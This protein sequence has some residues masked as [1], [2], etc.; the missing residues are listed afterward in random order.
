MAELSEQELLLLSTIIYEDSIVSGNFETIESLVDYYI[1]L[2]KE[3]AQA[4]GEGTNY[5]GDF[6]HMQTRLDDGEGG[7]IPQEEFMYIIKEINENHPELLKLE[8]Q[9]PVLSEYGRS[10]ITAVCLVNPDDGKATVVIRGTDTSYTAWRDNFEHAGESGLTPM[11]QSTVD[12]I[13]MLAE[14]GI[15][16]ITLTGH[17]KAAH[18]A[19]VA[20]I[21]RGDKISRCVGFDGQ[22][23][24][25]EFLYRYRDEIAANRRRRL[26]GS[27]VPLVN[28]LPGPRRNAPAE[29]RKYNSGTREP[30]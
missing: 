16:D 20:T 11:E 27:N 9:Y 7:R 29:G 28:L 12:Y 18:M 3:G 17:S 6:G 22:G 10:D 21:V 13:D 8:I 15:T 30:G 26:S 23:G 19:A 25:D 5:C 24:S 14:M 2:D 1:S 4:W